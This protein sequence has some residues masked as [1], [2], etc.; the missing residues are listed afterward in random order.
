MHAYYAAR[1][2]TLIT[3]PGVPETL[4]I[5]ARQGARIV[6]Y[7]ESMAFYSAQRLKD[8]RSG[9]ADRSAVLPED[10]QLPN[11]MTPEQLRRYPAERYELRKT[12]Q[13]FTPKGESSR[14][15]MF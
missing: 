14:T 5:I 11:N 1:K 12:V 15:P 3:Y 4:A 9:F 7:T 8:T 13:R 10:H 2:R 6:A